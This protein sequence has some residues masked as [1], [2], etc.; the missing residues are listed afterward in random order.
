MSNRA[1][2]IFVA[3]AFATALG[4]L[5]AMTPSLAAGAKELKP[6]TEAE[7]EKVEKE[8]EAKL[9]N[10]SKYE[11]CF[12]VAVKGRNDCSG[13]AGTTC[14]GTS[15]TDYQGNAYK[16]VARGTCTTIKTPNGVGSLTPK[17]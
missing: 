13:D 11:K 17:T 5:A 6:L 14:A 16:V 7:A 15:T 12:G 2:S 8:T 3:G 1:L 4:S 10:L 9:K